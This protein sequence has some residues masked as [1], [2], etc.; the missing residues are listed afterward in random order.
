MLDICDASLNQEILQYQS[1]NLRQ[2]FQLAQAYAFVDLVDGGI[3]RAEFHDLRRDID[4]ETPIGGAAGGRHAGR[5]AGHRLDRARHHVHQIASLREKGPAVVAPVEIVHNAVP[6][7]DAVHARLQR[8]QRARRGETEIEAYVR[9]ARDHVPRA[10][11]GVEIGDLPGRG[12]EVLVALIPFRLRHFGYRRGHVVDRVLPE[13]R[14][15]DVALDA[16]H[17]EAAGERAA[18]PVFHHVAEPA[19]ASGLA[20]QTVVELFAA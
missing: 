9:F 7:E 2:L 5:D 10:G 14:I 8:L 11:A 17:D 15:G 4:E 19:H 6:V 16:L 13:M 3:D 1:I 20:D 12:R 18:T